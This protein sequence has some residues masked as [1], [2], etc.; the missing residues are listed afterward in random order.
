MQIFLAKVPKF[1][2]SLQTNVTFLQIFAAQNQVF[3]PMYRSNI[4]HILGG[5]MGRYC[6]SVI[7]PDLTSTDNMVSVVFTRSVTIF[8]IGL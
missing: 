6:G 7:P 4:K 2:K 3:P 1:L 8:N 5:L